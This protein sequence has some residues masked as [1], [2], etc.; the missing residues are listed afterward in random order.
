MHCNN[1]HQLE[2]QMKANFLALAIVSGLML[3]G[4]LN[5]IQGG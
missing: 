4:D 5:L 3:G 2:V 1:M